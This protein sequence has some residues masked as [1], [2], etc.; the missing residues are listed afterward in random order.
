MSDTTKEII[1]VPKCEAQLDQNAYCGGDP[2]GHTC[3][4]DGTHYT[5]FGAW[6]CDECEDL[7]RRSSPR[8]SIH[9]HP[10]KAHEKLQRMAEQWVNITR[11]G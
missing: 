11:E 9:F 2:I 10:F 1:I 7:A 5:E 6:L 3:F 4:N 8:I